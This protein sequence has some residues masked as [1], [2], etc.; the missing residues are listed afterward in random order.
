MAATSI[1]I[2]APDINNPYVYPSTARASK[3]SGKRTTSSNVQGP[4]VLAT[5]T[6]FSALTVT[7]EHITALK[8][9][10]PHVTTKTTGNSGPSAT[11]VQSAT[12]ET[13]S[14]HKYPDMAEAT[15]SPRAAATAVQIGDLKTHNS[16]ATSNANP[17]K[18]K[19][20]IS[21][22]ITGQV[23]NHTRKRHKK[24][25]KPNIRTT[26]SFTG[27]TAFQ[28]IMNVPDIDILKK[29]Q[30]QWSAVPR[31]SDKVKEPVPTPNKAMDGTSELAAA[32]FHNVKEDG[33][34]KIQSPS[35]PKTLSKA[36]RKKQNKKKK[37]R[38]TRKSVSGRRQR[39]SIQ[40]LLRTG[41]QIEQ[42]AAAVTLLSISTTEKQSRRL[43]TDG[44]NAEDS[45][46]AP[47]F[48]LTLESKDLRRFHWIRSSSPVIAFHVTSDKL[49]KMEA[50]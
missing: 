45:R 31:A 3:S 27:V 23:Q 12:P 26:E 28:E 20:T 17:D 44:I 38:Q 9:R 50:S 21:N 16:N 2:A 33:N 42:M 18:S 48:S 49:K 19:A 24:S 5:P 22:N 13:E 37:E 11:A 1:Q 30:K 41:E 10:N 35:P 6:K 47:N 8:V 14:L 25:S 7:E 4:H 15:N 36:A 40:R 32:I 39:R 46:G 34:S 43:D 29:L